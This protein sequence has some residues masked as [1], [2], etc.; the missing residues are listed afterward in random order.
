MAIKFKKE[1]DK[2]DAFIGHL[3]RLKDHV[4][5]KIIQ[6][7]LDKNIRATE[8]KLHGAI[9]WDEGDTLETLQDQRNDRVELKNLPNELIK[10]YEGAKEFP[11]ELDPYS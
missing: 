4:G 7:V 2:R 5:W 6:K 8:G 3:K 10:E 11:I 9:D 1:K